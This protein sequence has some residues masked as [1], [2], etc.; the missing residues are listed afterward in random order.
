M[1]DPKDVAEILGAGKNGLG[2]CGL[3]KGAVTNA[4]STW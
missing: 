4:G 3:A 1:G 2:T